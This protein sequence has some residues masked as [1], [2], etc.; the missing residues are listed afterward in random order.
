MKKRI[1]LLVLISLLLLT[2]I[3]CGSASKSAS[4]IRDYNEAGSAPA[5]EMADIDQASEQNL[6]LEAAEKKII[7]N[8]EIR[9]TVKNNLEAEGEVQELV[10]KYKGYIQNSESYKSDNNDYT[11]ME[12]RLPAENFEQFNAELA[13]IGEITNN[14]VYT[15]DVTEEYIDLSARQKTLSIQEQRLQE[16]LTQTKNVDELLKVEREL[17]RVRGEIERITGRLRYLDN[18]ISY[19]TVRLTLST[20]YV[21]GDKMFDGFGDDVLH[22]LR[23]GFEAFL[24]VLLLLIKVVVFLLPFGIVALI[25]LLIIYKIKGRD[26]F[27]KK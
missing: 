13:D 20:K 9:I 6:S 7:K 18:K 26:F 4:S 15:T 1:L 8:A 25:V 5:V 27:F 17:A 14:R 11:N 16:M 19:S 3:G 12:I 10:A 21:S 22:S 2:L 23:A 24:T